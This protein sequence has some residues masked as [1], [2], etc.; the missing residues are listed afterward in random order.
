MVILTLFSLTFT[1]S[2]DRTV[3]PVGESFT[4]SVEIEGED[5][6]EVG[7]P[8]APDIPGIDVLGSS[9]SHSTQINFVNGKL[10]KSTSITFDYQMIARK[11]GE[12]TIPSFTLKFGD[13]EYSTEPINISIEKGRG[14][15][16]ISPDSEPSRQSGKKEYRK[17]FL[18]SKISR[19]SVYPGEPV[20]VTHFLYS[21]VNLADLRIK[22]PPSYE[23][24]WVENLQSPTRLNFTRTR[25]GS[26]TYSRALIKKDLLFPLEEK[27]VR[28]KPLTMELL[29]RGDIFVFSSKRQVISSEPETIRVKPFPEDRLGEFI[30]AVGEF[31]FLIQIDTSD[32]RVNSPFSLKIIIEGTGNLSLLSPPPFPESRKLIPYKPESKEETNVSGGSV[33]GKRIFTYLINPKVSGV[34]QIPEIKWAYFNVEKETFIRKKMGPWKIQVRPSNESGGEERNK[35]VGKD[36]AYIMPVTNKTVPV[37]P[38]FFLLYFLPSLIILLISGYYVLELKKIQGDKNYANIK[39]IPKELKTGFKKI[40]SEKDNNNVVQFY[41]DLTRVL[42]KFLKLKFNLNIFSMKREELLSELR[43]RNVPEN[44][45]SLLKEILRKSEGVRFTALK[46]GQK[47]MNEDFKNLREIISA[48]Y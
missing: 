37:M 38:K 46:P 28:I 33:K 19:S 39:A 25:I 10:S 14:S 48:L 35:T 3:I 42:L 31:D 13:K 43:K 26:I 29:T 23:N 45:I 11:Q 47:E 9:R 40:E 32:V 41:E 44:A 22:E 17:F 1:A 12:I 2:V 24:A 18:E 34:V 5:L 36:I 16:P 21:R 6:S 15:K 8:K 30:D 20:T 7:E 4:V 27:D